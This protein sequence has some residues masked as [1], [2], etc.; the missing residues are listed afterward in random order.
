[1]SALVLATP[2]EDPAIK[3]SPTM[4]A[5]VLDDPLARPPIPPFSIAGT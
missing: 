4:S 3:A 1:M 5:V 2:A